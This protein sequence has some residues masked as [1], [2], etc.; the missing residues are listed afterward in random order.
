MRRPRY[1]DSLHCISKAKS[2]SGTASKRELG[3]LLDCPMAPIRSREI[4]LVAARAVLAALANAAC[5]ALYDEVLFK[6]SSTEKIK[7]VKT[8]IE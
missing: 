6:V 7:A 2:R 8:A 3:R 5:A 1:D 4:D